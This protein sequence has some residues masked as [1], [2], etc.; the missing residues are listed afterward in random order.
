V[1]IDDWM[2]EQVTQSYL[3]DPQ[4]QRWLE[5]SNPWALQ[6]MAER[7]NEAH[8]RGMWANPSSEALATIMNLLDR[9][10]EWREGLS[11]PGSQMAEEV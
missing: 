2:Y 11:R 8:Q 9:G 7:L 4:I 5:E 10:E 1:T 3:R 6:A